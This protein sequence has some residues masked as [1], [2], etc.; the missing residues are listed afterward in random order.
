MID[1]LDYDDGI[2][3]EMLAAYIDGNSTSDENLIIQNALGSDELLT[4]AI[5]IANDCAP[6]GN[7]DWGETFGSNNMPELRLS[8]IADLGHQ[9][10]SCAESLTLGGDDL[11]GDLY[12][13]GL[14]VT[15]APES[16]EDNQLS[17]NDLGLTD[18]TDSWQN[19]EDINNMD[20]LT[21]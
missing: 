7:G 11:F 10:L 5:D 12:D 15:D 16:P 6:F 8:S 18:S 4:E 19:T 9:H 1:F 13:L 2:S 20:I 3:D 17:S 14:A 21:N